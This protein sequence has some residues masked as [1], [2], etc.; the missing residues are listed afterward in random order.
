MELRT[1]EIASMNAQFGVV[2]S[3]VLVYDPRQGSSEALALL[4]SEVMEHHQQISEIVAK[5][6]CVQR[7]AGGGYYRLVRDSFGQWWR[8]YLADGRAVP[9]EAQV[10]RGASVH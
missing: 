2:E 8:L 10:P 4:P 7:C 6:A 3:R 5:T 9:R 1:N